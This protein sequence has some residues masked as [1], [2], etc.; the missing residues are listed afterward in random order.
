MNLQGDFE[1]LTLASIL[2]LLCNDQKT[3]I[4]TVTNGE[5]NSRVF[6]D[7]GTI[8][9]ATS[10]LKQAR[11]GFL[12]QNAGV[13]SGR[14]LSKCLAYARENKL[15]LG[16]VLVQKGYISQDT[17][18]KYNTKQVEAIL[19]DLL[20]WEKGKFE[21]K[22]ARLNL[23][24]MIV[25]QL[26]PMKLI[27]EASRR[28]DELSVLRKV[29]PSDKLVF[30][31]SGK[32]HSKEE[33]KLNANEWRVLSLIDG[34]RSV[35]QVIT[36]SSYDEFAVY[37]I[38]FSVISS[39]LIEQK[40]EVNLTDGND[41][42]SLSGVLTMFND[43]LKAMKKNLSAEIGEKANEI[44]KETQSALPPDFQTI[45]LDYRIENPKNANLQVVESALAGLDPIPDDH[46]E[47][48]I[49]GFTTYCDLILKKAGEIIGG[50]PL[51]NVLADIEKVLDYISKY[52]SSSS[53][54]DRIVTD[55]K[56]LISQARADFNI[57]AKEPKG[58]KGLF[59]LFS[60][61]C[62]L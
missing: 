59:S 11:L 51:N 25:T 13:I 22:D 23:T 61:L 14:Q 24:N 58:K 1:G 28:I 5:E 2:Q 47:F 36:E 57:S 38:L 12:L 26:N 40:Q 31:M 49:T 19:Y 50:R 7:Q 42:N 8:V 43:I 16:K 37:K 62:H 52:Q 6:F 53:D 54:K 39:G 32:V 35:R 18:K 34:T 46:K 27:L 20:L 45:L 9:Y 56:A 29:I 4:L 10:P 33:I 55:L 41:G 15:H 3:G 30:K 44:F 60:G 48:L 21:Y 17:L